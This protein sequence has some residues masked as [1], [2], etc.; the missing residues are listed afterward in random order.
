[1]DREV[2]ES[3]FDAGCRRIHFGIES[4]NEKVLRVMRKGVDL[5]QARRVFTWCRELGIESLAYFMIGNP[6]E[7]EEEIQDTARYALSLDCDYIHVAVTTPFPGTELYRMGLEKGIIKTDSWREFAADPRA[8]FSPPLWEER[9][10][11]EALVER[12]LG[13]YRRFYHRP[14]YIVKRL[15]RIR[16]PGELVRK[17]RAGLRL[18]GRTRRAGS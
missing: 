14:G 16:S 1:M 12:M 17:A 7:G 18:L 2:L 6:E 3:L 15:W 13:L 5:E 8:D 9:L 4:G 11:R 10:S